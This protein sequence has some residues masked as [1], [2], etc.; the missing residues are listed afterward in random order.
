MTSRNRTQEIPKGNQNPY[1]EERHKIRWP[2]DKRQN[3]N[4]QNISQKIKDRV[5]R[6]PLKIGVLLIPIK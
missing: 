4:L 5:T 6:T 2:K 1:I 3:N